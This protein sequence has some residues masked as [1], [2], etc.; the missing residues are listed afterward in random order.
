MDQDRIEGRGAR[1]LS[2]RVQGFIESMLGGR[3]LH[4]EAKMNRAEGRIPNTV[5]GIKV[6]P[7]EDERR[8][9]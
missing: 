5:G 9:P 7:R 2:G 6:M 3:R 8:E 4:A 1:P